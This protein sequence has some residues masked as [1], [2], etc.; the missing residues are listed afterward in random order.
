MSSP[1]A[2]VGATRDI[3]ET[4]KETGRLTLRQWQRSFLAQ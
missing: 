1:A 3:L 4:W 2:E